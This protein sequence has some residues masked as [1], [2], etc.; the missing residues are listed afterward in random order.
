MDAL[1]LKEVFFV[2]DY[3]AYID[4][5]NQPFPADEL[6]NTVLFDDLFILNIFP[7]LIPTQAM[8]DLNPIGRVLH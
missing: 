3:F 4:A 8:C 5:L 6:H 2:V 1:L 7:I